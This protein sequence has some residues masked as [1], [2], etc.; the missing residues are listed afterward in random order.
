MA[1]VFNDIE[2]YE[3]LV[4]V[5]II[6]YNSARTVIETLNSI[7]NQSYRNIELVISDDAST[8]ATIQLCNKWIVNNEER[9]VHIRLLTS[10]H[11]TGTVKNLN[12]GVKAS[13]GKWIKGLAADDTLESSAISDYVS[14]VRSNKNVSICSAKLKLLPE[15]VNINLESIRRSY[16]KYNNAAFS[17]YSTQKMLIYGNSYVFPAPGWFYSRELYNEVGGFDENYVLME[18]WPFANAILEHG[19]R[20]FLLDKEL[21]NYRVTSKSVSHQKKNSELGN[22]IL[23]NDYRRYFYKTRLWQQLLHFRLDF[24]IRDLIYCECRNSQYKKGVGC[25]QGKVLNSLLRIFGRSNTTGK[26]SF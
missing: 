23:F 2:C 18:E 14:F 17:D 13:M 24:L 26:P 8:D 25:W 21:V 9:F 5:V 20:F 4:S 22:R 1:H 11:N 7:K 15:D 19:Y 3:P 6:T 16:E 10:D 12:R